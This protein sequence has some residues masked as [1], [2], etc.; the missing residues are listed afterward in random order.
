MTPDPGG[1][2]VVDPTN[3][4]SWN[5][6]AYVMNNPLNLIDLA[7]L[8]A[9]YVGY[10]WGPGCLP[11]DATGGGGGMGGGQNYFHGR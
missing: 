8:E 2:G 7:G 5:R 4:Q 9:C 6:Y 10:L 11:G 1:L 3:P